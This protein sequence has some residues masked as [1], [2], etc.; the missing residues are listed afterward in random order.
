MK[1]FSFGL[2]ILKEWRMIRFLKGCNW[3]CLGSCLIGS[4]WKRWIDSMNDCSKK[5][6][7]NFGKQEGW[8]MI[9]MNGRSL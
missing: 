8:C 1:V 9:G 4:L 7:F 5:R 3:K 6:D 2:T